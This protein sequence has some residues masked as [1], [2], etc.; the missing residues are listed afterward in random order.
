MVSI[1]TKRKF[2]MS[3]DYSKTNEILEGLFAHG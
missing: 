3:D 1:P 2:E